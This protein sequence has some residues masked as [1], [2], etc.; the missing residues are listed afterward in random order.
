[1]DTRLQ[2]VT[3]QLDVEVFDQLWKPAKDL[4][5]SIDELA[6]QAVLIWLCQ[7]AV[8]ES[9]EPEGNKDKDDTIKSIEDSE[10]ALITQT[11]EK[12]SG[13]K[14]KAAEALGISTRTLYRGLEK[15][16]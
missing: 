2:T 12:Y 1:M 6:R 14:S 8:K 13:N 9:R 11:L 15:Y 10:H 3:F 4:G 16:S 5:I 7:R